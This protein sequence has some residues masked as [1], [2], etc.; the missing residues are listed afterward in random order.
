MYNTQKDRTRRGKILRI[1]SGVSPGFYFLS[2]FPAD[3]WPSFTVS[4]SRC[5]VLTSILRGFAAAVTGMVTDST[6]LS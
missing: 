1:L 3:V 2:S 5:S 4:D 6:P